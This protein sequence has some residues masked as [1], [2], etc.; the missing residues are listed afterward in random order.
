M[1]LNHVT[2]ENVSQDPGSRDPTFFMSGY[3]EI[4]EKEAEDKN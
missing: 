4:V 3:S 2:E 1:F